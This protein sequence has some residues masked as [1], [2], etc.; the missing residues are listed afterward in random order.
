M[1]VET[2]QAVV[3]ALFQ[4]NIDSKTAYSILQQLDGFKLGTI[5]ADSFNFAVAIALKE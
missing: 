2:I 4:T 3:Q 5:K 1:T